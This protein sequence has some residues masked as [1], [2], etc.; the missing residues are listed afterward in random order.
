MPVYMSAPAVGN[1]PRASNGSA[2]RYVHPPSPGFG[3]PS[4][5]ID[6]VDIDGSIPGRQTAG[7]KVVK[8]GQ[9]SLHSPGGRS[10]YMGL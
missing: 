8:I 7:W 3:M 5:L 10:S 6:A 9:T 2:L 1:A 4:P